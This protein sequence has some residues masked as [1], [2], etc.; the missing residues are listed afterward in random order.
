MLR[1]SKFNIVQAN[2]Y[3]GFLY[4]SKYFAMHYCSKCLN[5]DKKFNILE[6]SCFGWRCAESAKSKF[7]I[8]QANPLLGI[9]IKKHDFD[10]FI[11]IIIIKTSWLD[12]SS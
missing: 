2:P 8:A 4:K 6:I 1:E 9:G 11:I 10:G 3:W 5:C 12:D 7:N